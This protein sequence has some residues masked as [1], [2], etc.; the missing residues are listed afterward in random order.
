MVVC[1]HCGWENPDQAAFCTN[2]GRG[3]G[4]GRSLDG[5]EE[6]TQRFRALGAR[7]S[8]PPSP[9]PVEGLGFERPLPRLGAPAEPDR[10]APTLLDFRM[11]TEMRAE[12]AR[13]VLAPRPEA[14]APAGDEAD[15]PMT[16]DETRAPLSPQDAS[17]ALDEAATT[18]VEDT[19][20]LLPSPVTLSEP[21]PTFDEVAPDRSALDEPL[22]EPVDDAPAAFAAADGG[23]EDEADAFGALDDADDDP[24]SSLHDMVGPPA[25][26]L[27][28]PRSA[29]ARGDSDEDDF[30]EL[31][32]SDLDAEDDLGD[33]LLSTGD[34][35]AVEIED[36]AVEVSPARQRPPPLPSATARY[37]LRPLSHNIAESKLIP[38][39]EGAV[40]IGRDDGDVRVAEDEF[41]SPRHAR[42]LL[43]EE[44]LYVEDLESLNGTWLRVRTEAT[45]EPGDVILIGQQILRLERVDRTA[46]A[47]VTDGTRR[48][49]GGPGS[50]YR[51]VQLGSDGQPLNVYHLPEEGC[52]IG[53]HI[54]DVVFTADNFMSGTHAVLRPANG[55]VSVRDLS[56]RNG[57]WVR[58]RD[59]RALE[60]GDAVMLGQTVWRVALPVG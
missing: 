59:R 43:D 44:A 22:A 23:E 8:A 3:L 29:G 38:V 28:G 36:E 14:A 15:A 58:L 37:L 39:G 57:T 31:S 48:L 27:R 33:P 18:T 21:A 34:F 53:R 42:F 6:S 5:P 1:R 41:V 55:G 32:T 7:D 45:L 35:E 17:R 26:P 13:R 9:L 46:A 2:C 56:S 16:L 54:A 49:G 4:R 47:P 60:V 10:G 30:E 12:L 24:E 40:V 25:P 50:R 19:A 11:P 51:L 52:R 20:D